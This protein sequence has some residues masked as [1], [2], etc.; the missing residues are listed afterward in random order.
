[1][2]GELERGRMEKLGKNLFLFKDICNV[3][4]IRKGTK[5]VLI[6]FG[7][8]DVLEELPS[9][10]IEA[11]DMVIHTNHHRDVCSG[12]HLLE[13]S[14]KIL[15]PE[16]EKYLF[17]AAE[18]FWQ[19]KKIYVMYPQ[20]SLLFTRT[21]NV[22]CEGLRDGQILEWEGVTFEIINTPGDSRNCITIICNMEGK[23]TLFCGDL[24]AAPG[25]V[26]NIYDFQFDYMP[27]QYVVFKYWKESLMKLLD[28]N[29][30]LLCPSHGI[31][32]YDA[33]DALEL[34][35]S[36]VEKLQYLMTLKICTSGREEI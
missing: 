1:M 9:L 7:N 15:V 14:V 30:D 36:R 21:T 2:K 16:G 3:Y 5:G 26:H 20:E 12:D 6:D 29:G 28:I 19:K 17:S 22:S 4:I 27:S 34:L 10:G 35:I 33:R 25:K 8:G 31:A 24:I 32:M 23:K 13:S 18:E 11:I